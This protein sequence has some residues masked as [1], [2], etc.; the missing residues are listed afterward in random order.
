[1]RIRYLILV[2][3]AAGGAAW[4]DEAPVCATT[5][6][7][8]YVLDTVGSPYAIKAA[9]ELPVSVW[10]K[11]GDAVVAVAPGGVE[12]VVAS[13]SWSPTAGGLWT[14]RR[15]TALAHDDEAAFTVRHSLFGTQGAGTPASPAKIVDN[16]ELVDC[17]A[18][19]GYVFALEGADGLMEKIVLPSGLGIEGAGG[20]LWRL[21]SSTDGCIYRCGEI[22]YPLNSLLPGPNRRLG[23]RELMPVAY[24]G[25][26]WL[27]DV[28]AASTVTFISPDGATTSIDKTGTGAERS[29]KFDVPGCW[30]VRLTAGNEVRGEALI[31]VTSGFVMVI[32]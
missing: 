9:G 2:A 26:N 8:S 15:K 13:G 11:S 10:R 4:A 32:R 29:F 28:A 31:V 24:S 22:A 7:F 23:I 27:G 30:T 5:S 19:D 14:L 12:S 3:C 6:P 25:D 20:G 18:G 1:M 21:F 16:D 17:S